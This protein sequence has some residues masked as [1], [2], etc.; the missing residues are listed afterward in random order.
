MENNF[1]KLTFPALVNET[2]KKH[3]DRNAYAF[4][5]KN[6]GVLKKQEIRLIL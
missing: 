2:L 4:V 6:Q 5:G 1:R 3:G